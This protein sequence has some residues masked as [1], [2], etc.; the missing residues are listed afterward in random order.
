MAQRSRRAQRV[1]FDSC[2]AQSG[3]LT[4]QKTACYYGW[5]QHRIPPQAKRPRRL[6]WPRTSPFHGGNT[7]SNPVGDANTFSSWGT[8]R[9]M[10]LQKLYGLSGL[11]LSNWGI[12]AA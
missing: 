6:A 10:A 8:I 1:A 12:Q 5:C 2:T 9:G 7:G 11:K 3:A 4:V